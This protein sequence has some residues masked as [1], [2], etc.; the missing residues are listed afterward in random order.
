MKTYTV[1]LDDNAHLGTLKKQF[2]EAVKV[3]V[4]RLV[5]R[6]VS[7]Y[8]IVAGGGEDNAAVWTDDTPVKAVTTDKQATLQI[9]EL[10]DEKELPALY[11]VQL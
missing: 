10:P 9:Y 8:R 5:V 6:S 4:S 2:A 7:F 3:P 1:F 11:P